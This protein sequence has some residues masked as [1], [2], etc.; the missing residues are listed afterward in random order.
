MFNEIFLLYVLTRLDIIN[1]V[2]GVV[3]FFGFTAIGFI[4]I[5]LTVENVW[6]KYRHIVTTYIWI[7]VIATL[8]VII[9]PDKKEAMFIVAGTGVIEA[10][11]SDTAQR[12]AGKSV[13]IVE[14]YLDKLEKA[15]K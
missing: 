2:A 10:V 13:Q 9:V 14:N 5:G 12:L 15:S 1:T 6:S 8:V 4:M 3:A 7:P 11:K